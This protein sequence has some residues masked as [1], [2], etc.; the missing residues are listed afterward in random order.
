MVSCHQLSRYIY[1]GL[2]W[3]GILNTVGEVVVGW[4]S[5]Q[6]WVSSTALYSACMLVCGLVTALIPLASSYPLV[7]ALSAVYGLE[8]KTKAIRRLAKI[9]Q[10][11]AGWLA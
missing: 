11:W 4:L 10:S 6:A 8:L 7:L 2:Y 9:S 3:A 1:S 5:D